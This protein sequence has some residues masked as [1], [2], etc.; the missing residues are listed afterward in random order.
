MSIRLIQTNYSVTYV[1]TS[2][3]YCKL[4][5]CQLC[6]TKQ[7]GGEGEEKEE[8]EEK[9]KEERHS[10]PI[11]SAFNVLV[12]VKLN[13]DR[14]RGQRASCIGNLVSLPLVSY[15][16]YRAFA[17]VLPKFPVYNTEKVF[18]RDKREASEWPLAKD[19]CPITGHGSSEMRQDGAGDRQRKGSWVDTNTKSLA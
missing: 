15:S 4:N 3:I 2:I 1:R 16:C 6:L 5:I 12:T 17:E 13:C 18:L 9:E 19:I 14:D 10:C 7:E 11:V 8:E